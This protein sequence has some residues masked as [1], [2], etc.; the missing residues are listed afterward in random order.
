MGN[1]PSKRLQTDSEYCLGRDGIIDNILKSIEGD[2]GNVVA[3]CGPPHIG[4]SMVLIKSFLKQS[5]VKDT[6]GYFMYYNFQDNKNFSYQQNENIWM[7]KLKV[8]N[9]E[10]QNNIEDHNDYRTLLSTLVT[11]VALKH[12]TVYLFLDNVDV[13]MN[14]GETKFAEFL[15]F[16]KTLEQTDN[17]V[18]I[19]FSTSTQIVQNRRW[20][21]IEK[22]PPL[23]TKDMCDI[24]TSECED[25]GV[26]IDMQRLCIPLIAIL[27]DGIPYAAATAGSILSEHGG[28]ITP[29]E[30]LEL[31]IVERLD[32][33]SPSNC[34]LSDRLD[35]MIEPIK[36]QEVKEE[37]KAFLSNLIMVE[38]RKVTEQQAY[39]C[40]GYPNAPVAM[41]KKSVLRPLLTSFILVK[42]HDLVLPS[43][44]KECKIA[45]DKRRAEECVNSETI[46]QMETCKLEVTRDNLKKLDMVFK[47]TDNTSP[48]DLEVFLQDLMKT[49]S[50]TDD[51]ISDE[52]NDDKESYRREVLDLTGLKD[53]LEIRENEVASEDAV[54]HNGDGADEEFLQKLDQ[55]SMQ[56]MSMPSLDRSDIMNKDKTEIMIRYVDNGVGLRFQQKTLSETVPKV[57]YN[58][59]CPNPVVYDGF[60]NLQEHTMGSVDL[61]SKQKIH[62]ESIE[63]VTSDNT[64]NQ[65][66]YNQDHVNGVYE[67]SELAIKM[68]NGEHA[69]THDQLENQG[70]YIENHVNGEYQILSD[71]A[72]ETPDGEDATTNARLESQ[73]GYIENHGNETPDGDDA[74]I[75]DQ[76]QSHYFVR[77]EI[78]SVPS[79]GPI[80]IHGDHVQ[81]RETSSQSA[82]YAVPR[83][84]K[85]FEPKLFPVL[86]TQGSADSGIFSPEVNGNAPEF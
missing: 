2:H 44:F 62:G 64:L 39:Y 80:A 35:A 32:V 14:W 6:N 65:G 54:R 18:K 26:D 60:D 75:N 55:R 78:L 10:E 83:V 67:L 19:I 48:K 61:L 47:I 81:P 28:L 84:P 77:S 82:T 79:S 42:E 17:N 27:C 23:P 20:P 69:K 52:S 53:E 66:G 59:E 43:V 38:S 12:K 25:K 86:R 11:R 4:K 15:E 1:Q 8:L 29:V 73:G 5:N 22:I 9:E 34:P 21:M 70:G 45:L 71:L 46:Q 72:I 76:L 56:G 36:K 49:K 3:I 37:V 16:V 7:S 13:L 58:S 50:I 51:E 57:A 85:K 24:I 74:T 33:L 30:L 40:N 68:P 63:V 41:F 31:M